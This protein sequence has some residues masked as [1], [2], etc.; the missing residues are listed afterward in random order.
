M[1]ETEPRFLEIGGS[2]GVLR[3]LAPAGWDSAPSASVWVEDPGGTAGALELELQSQHQGGM[4]ACGRL[5][6]PS[7]GGQAA[8][9]PS[10]QQLPRSRLACVGSAPGA[11]GWTLRATVG[12]GRTHDG[13]W[14]VGLSIGREPLSRPFARGPLFVTE[15][16]SGVGNASLNHQPGARWMRLAV[17]AGATPATIQLPWAAPGVVVTVPVG[18]AWAQEFDEQLAPI[19]PVQS[20]G[21]TWQT[22]IAGAPAAWS[23][24]EGL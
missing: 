4:I 19:A 20:G 5:V 3:V 16:R 1:M 22:V 7:V 2:S 9:V 6:V 18:A 11:Q 17:H 23:L 13:I 12:A 24:V 21:T 8:G 15:Q 14:R 10:W